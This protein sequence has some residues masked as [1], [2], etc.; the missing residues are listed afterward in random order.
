VPFYVQ[1]GNGEVPAKCPI[2]KVE[3]D[4]AERI[5]VTASPLGTHKAESGEDILTT[6]RKRHPSMT[7]EELRLN[8]G[9]YYYCMARPIAGL[10]YGDSP[11]YNPEQSDELMETR[12]SSIGQLRA[13]IEQLERIC[14]VIQPHPKSNN[15]S[16]YGHEIRN[17]LLLA[18]TEVEAQ[19][20][21]IMQ[22]NGEAN[23]FNT[24]HYVQ[25]AE[26]LKLA[27]Y[28]VSFSYYPELPPIAPF[29]NWKKD[30][31]KPTQDLE[32]Y[33]AYN[34]IKHDRETNFSQATLFRAFQAVTALFVMLC[35]QHGWAIAL[36]GDEAAGAFL[37]LISAPHW[38]ASEI[39]VS[40]ASKATGKEFFKKTA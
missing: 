33:A 18:C 5:D 40:Y 17:I 25:L 11:G 13:L 31:S 22:R 23:C 1:V 36:R 29:E 12:A 30:S 10:G 2:W 16:A 37:R 6:L 15:L 19:W 38:P 24:K 14:R 3:Q 7:F 8:P 26:P 28:R 9:E 21:K 34:A 27:E 20:K 32:W 4:I 39:Y 35:A